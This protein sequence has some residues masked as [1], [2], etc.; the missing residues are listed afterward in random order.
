M[1]ILLLLG[2]ALAL[3][4]SASATTETSSSAATSNKPHSS[5]SAA[6]SPSGAATS[7]AELGPSSLEVKWTGQW[8]PGD[9]P[10]EEYPLMSVTN[11]DATRPLTFYQGWFYFYDKD[12]K[13][14]GRVFK[15]RS[16][17]SISPGQKSEV[18]AGPKKTDLPA[19][20]E[21]IEFVVTGANFG[22]ETAKFRVAAPPPEQRPAGG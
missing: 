7:G 5:G 18:S 22:S 4:C 8:K 19:G 3:G 20:T 1:R 10:S 13:Q 9:S 15:E 14:V 2:C 21:L 17:L 12:K 6:T 16:S 11:K